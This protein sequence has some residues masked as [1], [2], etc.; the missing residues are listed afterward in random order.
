MFERKIT[1]ELEA[2][3]NDL[4]LKRK[5][6]VLKG[7]RQ[8]GKTKSVTEFAKSNYEHVVYINFKLQQ[9]MKTAFAGSLDT[10]TLITNISAQDPKAVFVRPSAG[11][12]R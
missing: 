9:N 3:K 4:S 7:L 2:W 5:A 12:G 6:F 1:K 10:D 11:R 8:V